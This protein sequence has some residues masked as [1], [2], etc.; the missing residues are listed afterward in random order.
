M[1]RAHYS[2][3]TARETA[4]SRP[5]DGVPVPNA[6]L[7]PLA[8]PAD[9]PVAESEGEVAPGPSRGPSPLRR[10]WAWAAGADGA[11]EELAPP[12]PPP[13]PS[14]PLAGPLPSAPPSPPSPPLSPPPWSP[15]PSRA[16][17]VC[18]LALAPLVA[19]LLFLLPWPCRG[20]I[21]L[22]TLALPCGVLAVAML[23]S[24]GMLYAGALL[25]TD[26]DGAWPPV[27]YFSLPLSAAGL[28]LRTSRL[29]AFCCRR[30]C[31]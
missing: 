7:P 6:G 8:T 3:H 2:E 18:L 22:P 25:A 23:H 17:D 9:T 31:R 28:V 27:L 4:H 20:R 24:G 26:E 11:E 16:L 12:S 29:S 19:E 15:P 21:G 13:S 30:R 5:D 10:I 1:L 14:P